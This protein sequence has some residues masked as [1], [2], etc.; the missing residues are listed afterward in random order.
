MRIKTKEK[1]KAINL[2]KQG[3]SYSEIL[4]EIS[5]AKSTLSL[6]LRSVGLAKEQKQ[7]IT[8]KKL[9]ACLRGGKAKK[10]QRIAITNEI[11]E[12]ARKE[13]DKI[14]DRELW[15]IG[16][17]LHWAEGAKE[18]EYR[19]GIGIKFSNSDPKMILLFKKWLIKVF[20]INGSDLTYELYIH[21]TADFKKA[22]IYW[23]NIISIPLEKIRVYFKR[24]KIKTKR[25]NIGN[26]YH[27]LIT[28]RVNRSSG[29][30]RKINGWIEGICEKLSI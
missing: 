5:V 7:R 14:S 25:K 22:Q 26:D 1:E 4:K 10:D 16:T 21:E 9:A 18:K 30:N 8:E 6:W 28:I 3:L 15:L 12:K 29:L 19:P 2:R 13:I 20:S 11:K 17:A 27:G 24:N 23:S